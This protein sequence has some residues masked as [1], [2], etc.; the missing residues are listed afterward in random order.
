[1]APLVYV[2]GLVVCFLCT[3]LL[4]RAFARVRSRLLLWSGLCFAG[5]T[6][7]NALLVF[8]LI[9]APDV[10]LYVW[11]LGVAAVAMLVLLYGLVWESDR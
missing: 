4:L 1:M 7:S 11:R 8:D 3:L 2:L 10:N 5:L 9:F 6:A